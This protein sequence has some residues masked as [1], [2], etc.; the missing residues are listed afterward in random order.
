[1]AKIFK[2]AICISLYLYEVV[3]EG[4]TGYWKATKDISAKSY[5]LSSIL[6]SISTDNQVQCAMR[7]LKNRLFCYKNNVCHISD[8]DIPP[9]RNIS[10]TTSA[11]CYTISTEFE[12]KS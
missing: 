2:L 7:A 1:M 8:L 11:V 12:S 4:G 3:C 10:A 9:F 5:F 6:Q